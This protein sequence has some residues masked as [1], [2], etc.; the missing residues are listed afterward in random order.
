MRTRE[1]EISPGR[2]PGFARCASRGLCASLGLLLLGLCLVGPISASAQEAE[3]ALPDE[4]KKER[5]KAYYKDAQAAYDAGRYE[6]AVTLFRLADT[7]SPAPVIAYNIA[8]AYERL[9]R[10]EDA[11]AYFEGY[12]R[13]HKKEFAEPPSDEKDVRG[14]ITMMRKLLQKEAPDVTIDSVPSGAN[15]YFGDKTKLVGQT[16]YKVKLKKGEYRVFVSMAD[17]GETEQIVKVKG[18]EPLSFVFRLEK[19]LHAGVLDVSVNVKDARIYVDGKVIGLSPL[20]P[21]KG[22]PTGKHQLVVEKDRYGSYR[23]MVLVR[24]GKTT[25]VTAEI[26][27]ENPPSTWRA[28]LGWTSVGLGL[29]SIGGGFVAYYLADQEFNNTDKFDRLVM[30]QDMGYGIGG[31]LV[32]LG[33][34]FLIWEWARDVVDSKDLVFGSPREYQAF[35]R[36]LDAQFA[37]AGPARSFGLA[38]SWRLQ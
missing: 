23:A 27:L 15:V 13:R 35:H 21:M 28:G 33:F 11:I 10:Y 37:P 25:S 31:G 24:E 14:R 4:V 22:T 7:M 5:A 29:A 9:S 38:P 1:R 30:Y 34:T 16:P 20:P 2:T 36:Q 26:H 17:Y 12:L 19:L 8:S 3:L 6:D 18:N 32:G